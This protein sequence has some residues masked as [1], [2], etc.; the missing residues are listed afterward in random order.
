M[1][2]YVAKTLEN[3]KK[4]GPIYDLTME[5]MDRVTSYTFGEDINE[6]FLEHYVDR[7]NAECDTLL[8]DGDYDYFDYE[9]CK[10]LLGLLK[11]EDISSL[12]G[13]VQDVFKILKESASEVINNHTGIAI[14]M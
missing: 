7:I 8:D 6:W 9:K 13:E 2:I 11:G 12:P 1:R 14:E 4:F 10:K 3:M 5:S